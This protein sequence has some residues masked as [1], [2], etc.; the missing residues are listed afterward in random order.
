MNFKDLFDRYEKGEVTEE[1]R[2][3]I[4]E[5]IE[6]NKVINDYL[7]K[8][9]SREINF[10]EEEKEDVNNNK[11]FKNIKKKAKFGMFKIILISI[12]ATI[13]IIDIGVRALNSLYYNPGEKL[14]SEDSY[15]DRFYLDTKVFTE[16]HIPNYQTMYTTVTN[17]GIGKYNL[18]ILNRN[19][20]NDSDNYINI[21]LDKNKVL[22]NT[23]LSFKFPVGNAFDYDSKDINLEEFKKGSTASLHLTLN[24]DLTIEEVDNLFKK[25]DVHETYLAIRTNSSITMGFMPFYNFTTRDFNEDINIKEDLYQR[26]LDKEYKE[27]DRYLREEDHFKSLLNYM[28]YREEFLE[29][30]F[31][32][33]NIDSYMYKYAL[34]YIEK[35]GVKVYGV[36]IV[37]TTENLLKLFE[38]ENIRGIMVDEVRLSIYQK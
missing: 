11:D 13:L 36:T 26:L 33:N 1:E 3:I 16:L 30:L 10:L 4:E 29:S 18:G 38:D 12:I 19:D 23:F 31:D 20:F 7:L 9:F 37:G 6:K 35:N 2:K 24:N 8:D 21:N 15:F 34:E 22:E 25:Y 5:A 14:K 17:T 32:Y 27:E 28:S